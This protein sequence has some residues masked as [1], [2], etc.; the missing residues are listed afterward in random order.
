MS[1]WTT[2]ILVILA[3]TLADICWTKY[4]METANKN[5][6]SAGVWSALIILCGSFATVSFV[7]DKRFITAA[8]IGAFLGTWATI[9][10]DKR[11][12]K[13]EKSETV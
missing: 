7:S 5:A 4:F 12:D 10:W 9:T 1:F 6:T 3:L 8:M 2:Y 11:K 13:G